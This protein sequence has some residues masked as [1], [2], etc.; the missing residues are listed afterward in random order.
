MNILFLTQVLPY[1]LN[2]GPKI[3]AYYVLRHLHEAGHKVTLISFVRDDDQPEYLQHLRQF[4]LKIHTVRMRRSRLRDGLMLTKALLSGQPFL[5]ARD[6]IPEMVQTVRSVVGSAKPF[7]AVHSDQLWM[8]PY[9]LLARDWGS[10]RAVPMTVLDQ[11]NAVFNIPRRLADSEKNVLKRKLLELEASRMEKYEKIICG[12]FDKVVWVTEEDRRAL[13]SDRSELPS[14]EAVIPIAVEVQPHESS[15]RSG[16]IRRI[17]FMGGLH[18]PPNRNGI[19]WF[20]QQIWPLIRK[21]VPEVILTIIGR[22]PVAELNSETDN[23][24][25]VT[26]YLPDP[27][28]RL[29]ETAVFIVPLQA[30]GGMRVK[31]LDA[32][33]RNLPVV[34]TRIGAEGIQT[35][36]RENI[37]L[38]D[39][40]DGFASSVID[41]VKDSGLAARLAAEGRKT[42]EA[43]Y[44][45][46]TAYRA[47]DKIY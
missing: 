1:P 11:H 15:D 14:A 16:K 43:L 9:A 10:K 30:G 20:R 40:A 28:S 44:D 5:V 23:S 47:W 42:L 13:F 3:R 2:A 32:W 19:L 39:T 18:W 17:T 26:G 34:S 36:H 6:W 4:C 41:I 38:E 25:E 37:C 33:A 31:I 22:D 8:A 29:S 46:R 45:W 24:I 27:S 12:R 35:R 21:H 7:D